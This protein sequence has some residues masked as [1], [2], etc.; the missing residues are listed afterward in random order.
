[1]LKANNGGIKSRTILIE[2]K[3]EPTARDR[4][5]IVIHSVN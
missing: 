1:M 2:I 5:I 3:L 4:V